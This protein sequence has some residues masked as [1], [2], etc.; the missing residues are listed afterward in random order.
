M[1]QTVKRVSIWKPL[2][3]SLCLLMAMQQKAHADIAIVLL[4]ALGV[5]AFAF[6]CVSTTDAEDAKKAKEWD[7]KAAKQRKEAEKERA[8]QAEKNKVC[9]EARGRAKE[10]HDLCLL[11]RNNDNNCAENYLSAKELADELCK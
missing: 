7:E 6:L 4:G 1:E 9:N 10:I 11:S 3:L 8:I 2:V 5:T